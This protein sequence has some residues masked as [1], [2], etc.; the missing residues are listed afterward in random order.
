MQS[1]I[2]IGNVGHTPKVK[3]FDDGGKVAQ[4]SVA[5]TERGFRTKD[6]K[7]IPDHT[8]WFYVVLKGGLAK[9]AEQY[10]TSGSK[11]SV[12]GKFKTREYEKDGQKQK[13]TELI[14]DELELLSPKPDGGQAQTQTQPNPPV[15][16]EDKDDLPF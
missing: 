5:C 10:V 14:G 3:T 7:E 1:T 13:V 4:F 11:V 2:I 6:G 15:Q 12:R 9:V 16:F 8:E